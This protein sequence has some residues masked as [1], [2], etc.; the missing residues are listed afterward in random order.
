MAHNVK[1]VWHRCPCKWLCKF[2]SLA[3]CSTGLETKIYKRFRLLHH[4]N[5]IS[6][7]ELTDPQFT[8][9]ERVQQ[10]V[11]TSQLT[12]VVTRN[13]ALY[14]PCLQGSARVP[15]GQCK[16]KVNFITKA[17]KWG[18]ILQF[19]LTVWI[20]LHLLERPFKHDLWNFNFC[21]LFRSL[22][23]NERHVAFE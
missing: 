4:F 9:W 17:W 20:M 11:M 12:K 1:W 16:C 3:H 15:L 14:F 22:R 21:L 7:Q 6:V 13:E 5:D 10:C 18:W 19:V 8:V 23:F 2:W